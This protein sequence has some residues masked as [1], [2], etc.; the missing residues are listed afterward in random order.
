MA[1]TVR[2][3]S[4]EV[5]PPNAVR[6][7]PVQNVKTINLKLHRG[8]D[9]SG[10]YAADFIAV[11]TSKADGR[12]DSTPGF[13]LLLSHPGAIVNHICRTNRIQAGWTRHAARPKGKIIR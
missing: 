9:C 5:R 6:N 8:S 1:S 7:K 3:S 11:L 13:K 2:N 10:K 12:S 4:A